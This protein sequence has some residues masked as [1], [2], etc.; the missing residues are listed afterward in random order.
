MQSANAANILGILHCLESGHPVYAFMPVL[1]CD[2][3]QYRGVER[4][5]F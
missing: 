5:W 2:L 4:Y 3:N 1:C